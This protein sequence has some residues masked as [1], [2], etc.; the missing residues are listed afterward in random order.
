VAPVVL[1]VAS[2]CDPEKFYTLPN[3]VLLCGEFHTTFLHHPVVGKV[4]S[5]SDPRT[6]FHGILDPYGLSDLPVQQY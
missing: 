2:F 4:F 3:H 6:I 5:L 1:V